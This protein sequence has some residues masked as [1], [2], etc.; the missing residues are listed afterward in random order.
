MMNILIEMVNDS[1]PE[2][3]LA[4]TDALQRFSDG[5]VVPPLVAVL[6]DPDERV[7]RQAQRSLDYLESV[8]SS[9]GGSSDQ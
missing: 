5:R 3:R 9:R 1:S 4:V 6:D 7:A 8:V 2:I